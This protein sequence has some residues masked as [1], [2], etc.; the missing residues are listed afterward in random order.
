MHNCTKYKQKINRQITSWVIVSSNRFR[1]NEA[2]WGKN[3]G[4]KSSTKFV[5]KF[6]KRSGPVFRFEVFSWTPKYPQNL[7]SQ[8]PTPKH[9]TKDAHNSQLHVTCLWHFL[10]QQLWPQKVPIAIPKSLFSQKNSI[11]HP[12]HVENNA[13]KLKSTQH[14]SFTPSHMPSPCDRLAVNRQLS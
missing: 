6:Y 11:I 8:K 10:T 3:W 7:S 1:W 4:G 5:V 9:F 14:I 13:R 2:F 12:N